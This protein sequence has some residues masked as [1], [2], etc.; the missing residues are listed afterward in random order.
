[1][2]SFSKIRMIL[3]YL[4]LLGLLFWAFSAFSGSSKAN[5]VSF[6]GMTEYF[7]REEVTAFQVADDNTVTLQLKD[8][9]VRYHAL[10]DLALF[11]ES[12][13]QLIREQQEAGI[14]TD[15]DF[16][17][18]AE[19]PAWCLGEYGGS[20]STPSTELSPNIFKKSKASI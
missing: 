18:K 17:R 5:Y 11:D 2:K 8:G 20:Y 9:T 7:R 1:M 6:A 14:I 3:V 16:A 4:V 19:L 10:A 15:Y 12:L 13:G